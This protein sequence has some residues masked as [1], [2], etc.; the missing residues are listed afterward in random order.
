ML[1]WHQAAALP[2]HD[3]ESFVKWR[4]HTGSNGRDLLASLT[5]ILDIHAIELE[6]FEQRLAH[7]ADAVLAS[8]QP[9]GLDT[10]IIVCR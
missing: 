4:L 7:A 2:C 1:L 9:I 6:Q 3:G 8:G 10:I 5:T